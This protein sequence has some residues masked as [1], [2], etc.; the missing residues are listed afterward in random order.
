M[1][2]DVL[3]EYSISMYIVR[4]MYT[5]WTLHNRAHPKF[6]GDSERRF[7]ILDHLELPRYCQSHKLDSWI[8]QFTVFCT[9]MQS[10]FDRTR[11]LSRDGS[12]SPDHVVTAGTVVYHSARN[13]GPSYCSVGQ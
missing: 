1:R 3:F 12:L 7:D 9:K 11:L 10:L 6:S 13:L 2:V 4:V 5:V 8:F